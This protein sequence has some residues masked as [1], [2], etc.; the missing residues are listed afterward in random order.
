VNDFHDRIPDTENCSQ[1]KKDD[2][3]EMNEDD[4][5]SKNRENHH[6]ILPCCPLQVWT[7]GIAGL[8]KF[9]LER[10]RSDLNNYGKQT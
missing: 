10:S 7:R 5:V 3:E 9:I 2:P 1:D 8:R 6:I 4:N